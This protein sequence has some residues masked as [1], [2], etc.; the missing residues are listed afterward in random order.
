MHRL[1]DAIAAGQIKASSVS[2]QRQVQLMNNDDVSVRTHARQVLTAQENSNRQQVIDQYKTALQGTGDVAKGTLVFERACQQC[3]R[4]KGKGVNFGP[5]LA[6][7]RNRDA[8]FILADI[9][10]PNR[11]IA[12]AYEYWTIQLKNGTSEAGVIVSETSTAITVKNLAG[13]ERTIA[14][15][16]IRTLQA[17]PTSIMPE[18]LENTISISEMR[19]LL[20]YL[21]KG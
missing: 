11:S 16:E 7:I 1:L 6:S 5:D 4:I 10:N 20:A 2:W 17:L 9:L 18:G 12:D 13:S 15:S 3:H 14:R 8:Y 19:D 21:K